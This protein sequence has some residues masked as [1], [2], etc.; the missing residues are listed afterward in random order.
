MRPGPA[1]K[2]MRPFPS[3]LAIIIAPSF[4]HFSH[5]SHQRWEESPSTAG[6]CAVAVTKLCFG[7]GLWGD[8]GVWGGCPGDPADPAAGRGLAHK[9]WD[10]FKALVQ[11]G[12]ISL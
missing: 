12:Q 3:H 10:G 5:L 1:S 7:S 2:Q 11:P 6:E 9:S 4:P 8:T